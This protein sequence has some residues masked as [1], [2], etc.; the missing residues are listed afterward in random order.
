MGDTRLASAPA[1]IAVGFGWPI[2]ATAMITKP[3]AAINIPKPILRG[4][5]GSL[6]FLANA[7]NTALET[8]VSATTKKGLN[9]W[10]IWGRIGV[11]SGRPMYCYTR[12]PKQTA[13]ITEGAT[14]FLFWKIPKIAYTAIAATAR[15]HTLIPRLMK[16]VAKGAV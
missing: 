11:D 15:F 1:L 16:P 4:A 2:E 6:P 8:G 14:L 13:A 7:P 3:R 9:C 5:E 12:K 10:K